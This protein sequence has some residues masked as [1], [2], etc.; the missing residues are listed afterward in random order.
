MGETTLDPGLAKWRLW[1]AGSG[2]FDTR[3]RFILWRAGY[4]SRE[5][6][7]S[8]TDEELLAVRN[9]GKGMLKY[10][11]SGKAFTSPEP[12][13]QAQRDE[14]RAILAPL[15]DDPFHGSTPCVFCGHRWRFN[16]SVNHMIDCPVLQ[17]DRLLGR[18]P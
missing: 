12:S 6:V 5:Q 14:L 13:L 18:T 17:R 3:S 10:I 11:R 16:E 1:H 9:L 15:L 2:V 8:A 7:E 4:R